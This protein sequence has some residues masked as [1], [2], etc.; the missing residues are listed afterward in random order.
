MWWGFGEGFGEGWVEGGREVCR[1]VWWVLC[2][3]LGIGVP[4][5]V[6]W[7]MCVVRGGIF[8]WILV[9]IC[10][11]QMNMLVYTCS[12]FYT[13]LISI[14]FVILRPFINE[15]NYLISLFNALCS[16]LLFLYHVNCVVN[17]RKIISC[18]GINV[19]ELSFCKVEITL[20]IYN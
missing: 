15:L 13:L 9:H 3:G 4:W 12:S 6:R 16:H 8:I 1:G 19:I 20:L 2:W 11:Y 14:L 18:S 17:V 7:G 5:K 10:R